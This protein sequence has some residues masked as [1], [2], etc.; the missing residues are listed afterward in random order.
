MKDKLWKDR[1]GIALLITITVITL[2][3]ATVLEINRRAGEAAEY[4]A[5][6]RDRI[7]LS[8]MTSSGIQMAMVLLL[9]DKKEAGEVDSIQEEWSSEEA[10]SDALADIPFEDGKLGVVI[11]DE[12][13]KIQLNALV[14]FPEGMVFN[15]DQMNMWE[16]FLGYITSPENEDE[17]ATPS[18]IVNSVKDWLDSGDDDAITGVNGAESDYYE[19]LDPPYKCRNGPMIHVNELL[20]IKGVPALVKGAG[21]W[22]VISNYITVNG[23]VEETGSAK[24]TFPGQININ[25]AELPVVAALLHPDDVHLAQEIITYREEMSEGNYTHDLSRADWYKKAPGCSELSIEPKLI[26]TKSDFFRIT[27]SAEINDIKM[28]TVAVIQRENKSGKN[29]CKIL[30]WQTE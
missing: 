3:I 2:L 18:A 1:R 12:L 24:F 14:K 21:G 5:V 11:T 15:Q 27:A 8:Y 19:G 9:K 4:T 20:L 25:T 22:D 16:R 13:A 26:T 6:A 10:V 17:D 29:R 30:S 7:T 28:T 23:M